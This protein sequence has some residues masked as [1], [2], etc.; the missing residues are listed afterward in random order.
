VALH[1]ERLLRSDQ[2]MSE[3]EHLAGAA[4]RAG[5]LRYGAAAE[6]RREIVRRVRDQGYVSAAE[7][8]RD[9]VVSEM[10]VRR[11]IR[12]LAQAGHVLAV[13]GGAAMPGRS[14]LGPGFRAR[15]GEEHDAKRAIARAA[16]AQLRPGTVV[17]L[18][19]GTTVFEVAREL[20]ARSEIVV[21][22]HSLP[23]L[24]VAAEVDGI[25]VVSL[26]GL[27]LP[28]SQSFAGP[29]TLSAIGNLHIDTLV[30]SATA[31]SDAGLW[32]NS[33]VETETKQALIAAADR[34][35]VVADATKFDVTAAV[36]ICGWDVPSLVLTD[37]RI[38]RATLRRLRRAG[39]AVEVAMA[40]VATP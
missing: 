36:R 17:A 34:V 32:S 7:F 12:M 40:E 31:A 28:D 37:S 2:M 33:F 11:D 14:M 1:G 27:L 3:R 5:P 10:T 9:L 24:Q 23:V 6:R 35:L 29:A 38:D 8:S 15:R 19:A 22:T 30:L 25:T 20:P 16:A 13:R 39:A 26:G 4:G 21:V 18:D